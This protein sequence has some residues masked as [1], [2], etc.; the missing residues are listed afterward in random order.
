MASRLNRLNGWRRLWLAASAGLAIWL[1]V[2]W[3]LQSLSSM[4][5]SRY[6]YDRD[7]EKD[8]ANPQCRAYQTE[9]LGKLR[10]PGY[11]EGCWHIYTSRQYDKTVPYT[12]EAHKSRNAA[13][14]RE[15]YLI[16]LGMGTVGT[17]FV[18]GLVYFF[19]WLVGWILT[20]FR[21]QRS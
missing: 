15:Q 10:E 7:I 17:V 21:Q 14:S 20:G 11:S 3:P 4:H 13:N 9:P 19:G 8:F 6:S 12:L 5:A 18:S 1:V 16:A 2:V